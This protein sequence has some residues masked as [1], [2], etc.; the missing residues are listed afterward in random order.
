MYCTYAER[1]ILL[2]CMIINT[3][4]VSMVPHVFVSMVFNMFIFFFF[5]VISW[6]YRIGTRSLAY[7]SYVNPVTN[8][9]VQYVGG[10]SFM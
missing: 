3:R 5:V 4:E 6:R 2:K 10:L 9:E 7:Y 8:N 1:N